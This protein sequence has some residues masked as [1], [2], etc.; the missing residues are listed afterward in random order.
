VFHARTVLDAPQ[1]IH[2]A[3]IGLAVGLIVPKGVADQ[4]RA[5]LPYFLGALLVG[6]A[7]RRL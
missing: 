5:E 4:I 7:G 6:V 3:V 2:A 1:E